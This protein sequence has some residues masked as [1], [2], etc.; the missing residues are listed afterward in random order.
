MK[1]KI[2]QKHPIR[3]NGILRE[4]DTEVDIDDQTAAWLIENKRAIEVKSNNGTS[5]TPVEQ[6][7]KETERKNAIVKAIA[8]LRATNP[9]EVPSCNK[10]KEKSGFALKVEERDS[11][12]AELQKKNQE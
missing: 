4:P 2:T 1:V 3:Y 9:D 6:A 7:A 11:L 12:I 10:I 5:L 8:E